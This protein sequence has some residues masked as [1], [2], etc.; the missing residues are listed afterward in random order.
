MAKLN[1]PT[2]KNERIDAFDFDEGIIVARKYQIEEKIGSGWESEVYRVR[3]LS[4]GIERAAKFFFPHR[5]P[6]N[7]TSMFYAKK[8]H[9]LR[10]CNI[11]I[12]YITQET[13]TIRGRPVTMLVS[14]FV[15]G[16]L[17]SEFVSRQPGK[18]L[19]AFQALHLLHALAV[20]MDKIHRHNEY[21]GDLHSDNVIV[22]RSGLGFGLKLLDLYHWRAPRPENIQDDVVNMVH[23]FYEALG[24]PKHYARQPKEIKSIVCG[25]KRSL[26]LKKFRTAGQLRDY[27]ENMEWDSGS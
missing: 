25:L 1:A 27:L 22:H 10:E 20:G 19:G 14:E 11:L 5:N 9:K 7:K 17:L 2:R 3:E 26:I 18:R 13:L 8:L 23:I 21:H 4:T 16:E 24:G 15:E 6:K 12:Q